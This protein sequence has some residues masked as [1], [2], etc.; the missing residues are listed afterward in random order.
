VEVAKEAHEV[1]HASDHVHPTEKPA[2]PPES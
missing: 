2:G 1:A